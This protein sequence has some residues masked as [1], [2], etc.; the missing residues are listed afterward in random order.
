MN[1]LISALLA[2]S[3]GTGPT[4]SE[5]QA[6]MDRIEARISMPPG[7]SPL[8]LYERYYAWEAREDGVRKVFGTYVRGHGSGRHWVNQNEL[9]LVMDGG[10]GIVTLTY[11]VDADRVE[12][13]EC[14][15]DG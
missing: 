8:A 11:D 1:G 2:V 12:R 4:P 13:V 5:I 14:N 9:P 10:C 3:L 7:A 6:L 15:G